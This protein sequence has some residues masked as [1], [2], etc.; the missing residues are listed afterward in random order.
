MYDGLNAL[1]VVEFL[2]R[3]EAASEEDGTATA[4]W[5]RLALALWGA[6]PARPRPRRVGRWPTAA[7]RAQSAGRR[8]PEALPMAR[9]DARLRAWTFVPCDPYALGAPSTRAPATCEDAHHAT[10]CRHVSI[11]A[12]GCGSRRPCT[13][14][15]TRVAAA[16]RASTTARSR[17][18]LHTDD[19]DGQLSG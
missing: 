7:R 19:E 4:G 9:R 2:T 6:W 18:V 11:A 3:V 16:S 14:P 1:R 10:A 13:Q 8:H 12:P 5:R 17:S 15:V